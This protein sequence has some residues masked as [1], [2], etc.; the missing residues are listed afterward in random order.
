MKVD[1]W[2][3][4]SWIKPTYSLLGQGKLSRLERWKNFWF[5]IV[6]RI[7]TYLITKQEGSHR[8]CARGWLRVREHLCNIFFSVWTEIQAKRSSFDGALHKNGCTGKNPIHRSLVSKISG[9][10][11]HCPPL[12]RAFPFPCT[13]AFFFKFQISIFRATLVRVSAVQCPGPSDSFPR[14]V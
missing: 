8:R 7:Q 12:A 14:L 9:Q 13:L 2:P 5:A 4:A 3:T 10:T 11:C 1:T 6:S